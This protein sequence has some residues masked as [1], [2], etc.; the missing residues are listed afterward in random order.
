MNQNWNMFIQKLERK[1][2]QTTL[3]VSAALQVIDPEECDALYEFDLANGKKLTLA[4]EG[5]SPAYFNY[6]HAVLH[7]NVGTKLDLRQ[8]LTGIDYAFDKN[9]MDVLE[10]VVEENF[11]TNHA[12]TYHYFYK[13]VSRYRDMEL[14]SKFFTVVVHEESEH[15][16]VTQLESQ[17]YTESP[18]YEELNKKWTYHV[19]IEN[20]QEIALPT[21]ERQNPIMDE[22]YI[23]VKGVDNGYSITYYYQKAPREAYL[24]NDQ[25]L[26]YDPKMGL[27]NNVYSTENG[28]FD[29]S[30][31]LHP[32]K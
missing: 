6:K 4:V 24:T 5:D 27:Y 23:F 13:T 3:S 1:N 28:K 7:V 29:V 16:P 26:G 21:A 19:D 30:D 17:F 8:N 14:I 11:N 18:T 12:G 20:K 10:V 32:E 25:I 15:Y 2:K 9:L 31:S 22:E